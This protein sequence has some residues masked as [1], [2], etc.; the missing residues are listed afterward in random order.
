V[1]LSS[2]AAE[3]R[4]PHLEHGELDRAPVWQQELRRL[5]HMIAVGIFAGDMAHGAGFELE[6]GFRRREEITVLVA[7]M[8]GSSAQ[9]YKSPGVVH[10]C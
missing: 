6:L 7:R 9:Q 1:A 8:G 10:S 5:P 2:D 3:K 4:P